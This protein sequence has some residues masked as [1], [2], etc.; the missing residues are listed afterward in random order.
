MTDESPLFETL[1]QK[2]VR[3]K[4]ENEESRMV[5]SMSCGTSSNVR[6]SVV[7]HVWV[8]TAHDDPKKNWNRLITCLLMTH[9]EL[10]TWCINSSSPRLIPAI[11]GA[12]R[13]AGWTSRR[14]RSVWGFFSSKLLTH[15]VQPCYEWAIWGFGILY[16][17]MGQ[18]T[19]AKF[20]NS[21]T[22]FHGH[23]NYL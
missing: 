13:R 23:I 2:K 22:K 20:Q 19:S 21:P 1:E 7:T 14:R 9:H 11:H 5:Y 4:R 15:L 6:V 3:S 17:A 18:G 12:S 10:K 16:W 8:N